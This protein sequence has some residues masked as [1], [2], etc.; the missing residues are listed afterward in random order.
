MLFHKD[1]GRN[2]ENLARKFCFFKLYVPQK[3]LV[4]SN[5]N[6]RQFYKGA[7]DQFAPL[8][9]IWFIENKDIKR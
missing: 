7:I 1:Y 5:L 6:N 2:Y 4:I 8:T 9:H 3:R